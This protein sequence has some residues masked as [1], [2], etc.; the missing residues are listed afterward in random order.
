M[1]KTILSE[2]SGFTPVIDGVL[3]ELGGDAALVFGVI[4][5]YCQMDSGVCYAS[6][7]TIA[8]RLKKERKYVIR[9]LAVLVKN[10]FLKDVTLIYHP[11]APTIINKNGDKVSTGITRIYADTGKAQIIGSIVAG[12]CRNVDND[13]SHLVNEDI[14]PRTPS[15]NGIAQNGI[16]STNTHP[17]KGQGVSQKGMGGNP[18]RVGGHPKKGSHKESNQEIRNKKIEEDTFLGSSSTE[19]FK[20]AQIY[21]NSSKLELQDQVNQA[22][23]NTWVKS[24]FLLHFDSLTKQV[25]VG[26][27][28][29]TTINELKANGADQLL[30][31]IIKNNW[32]PEISIAFCV[33]QPANIKN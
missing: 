33:S 21:F 10:G 27:F 22:F 30:S 5:R 32:S 2:T 3:D 14:D 25:V 6:L 18:K 11:D 24:L 16:G 15:Q 23:Y 20:R 28:N 7:D 9:H 29:S 1:G 12:V 31:Q 4:W 13:E 17:Q 19:E 26:V 8:N